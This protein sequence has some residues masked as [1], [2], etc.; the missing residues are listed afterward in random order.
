MSTES[1]CQTCAA[2]PKPRRVKAKRCTICLE[3]MIAAHAE[4]GVADNALAC[5]NAHHVCMP[6]AR[7]L[8]RPTRLCSWSCSGFQYTCPMCRMV[9]CLTPTHVLAVIKGSQSAAYD[10]V[11]E[12]FACPHQFDTQRVVRSDDVPSDASDD[13]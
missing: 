10:L 5:A 8:V 3:T 12:G 6:C 11:D 1:L 2:A 9:A 7:K 13:E 4:G